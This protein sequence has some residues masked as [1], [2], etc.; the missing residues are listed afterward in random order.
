MILPRPLKSHKSVMLRGNVAVMQMKRLDV[1]NKI[2]ETGAGTSKWTRSM[3]LMQRRTNVYSVSRA[4]RNLASFKA[5]VD[6]FMK[7]RISNMQRLRVS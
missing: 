4:I 2:S 5:L 1:C 6:L 3:K 7:T